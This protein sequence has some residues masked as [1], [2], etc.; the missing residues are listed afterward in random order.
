MKKKIIILCHS[1]ILHIYLN[2]VKKSICLG[3]KCRLMDGLDQNTHQRKDNGHNST[4]NQGREGKCS[5][6]TRTPCIH[7]I[8]IITLSAKEIL[9]LHHYI[10][11]RYP[12]QL[13][14]P[15]ATIKC[16]GTALSPTH[17]SPS[18]HRYDMI[19]NK[20]KKNSAHYPPWRNYINS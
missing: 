12:R 3:L 18:L 7:S 16:L 10:N 2:Y 9:R 8:T 13:N 19:S 17:L 15:D 5:K 11:N 6:N 1:G 4:T 14:G 20:F